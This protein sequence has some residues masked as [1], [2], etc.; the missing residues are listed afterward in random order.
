MPTVSP[1]SVNSTAA[2][3]EAM[4]QQ[5]SA[6][7]PPQP[8]GTPVLRYRHWREGMDPDECV[9][10]DGNAP[11]R[12]NLSHWP[13]NRTPE[14][15]RHDLSTGSALMLAKAANRAALLE[16]ITTVT[17]NH[18]DTDGLCSA[19]AVLEPEKAMAKMPALISAAMAGDFEVFTTPEGVKIDLTLTA[20]TKNPHSPVYSGKFGTDLECREAQYAF[21]LELLPRLLENPDLHADWFAREY[22]TIQK[23]MRSIRE[24][25][26]HIDTHPGNISFST[27]RCERLYHRAAVNTMVDT[28]RVLMCVPASGDGWYY[29]LRTTT[30]SWFQLPSR[31]YKPRADWASLVRM[32]N[33]AMS[34]PRGEWVAE[35]YRDPAPSLAFVD[36]R[37]D[38]VPNKHKHRDVGA[39]MFAFFF[40][41][42][43]PNG[44][45]SPFGP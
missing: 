2:F 22:W 11:G 10:V 5:K 6:K 31:P 33:A 15:L 32:L 13:G 26:A 21:G 35:D 14:G 16:G 29:Q 40:R 30:R 4:T 25:N 18:W 28:D 36:G 38:L 20:L 37:G 9:S 3:V 41:A 39:V 45:P 19:W 27:L 42:D 1:R 43:Y 12:L 24:D 23:D 17:N 34:D 44:V 8:T 7:D